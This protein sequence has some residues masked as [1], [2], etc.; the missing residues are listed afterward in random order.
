MTNRSSFSLL[1]PSTPPSLR[2]S[3]PQAK[4]KAS[5]LWLL[6]KA[7]NKSIPK[8]LRDPYYKNAQNEEFL[9]PQITQG[10]TNCEL[11]CMALSYIYEDLS[12]AD[13]DHIG[14]I[15]LLIKK[16]VQIVEPNDIDLTETALIQ[17][18]PIRMVSS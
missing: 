7:Y 2:N 18:A 16:G 6:S 13:L 11:Y 5:I 4:E 1:S 8:D 12:Y 10:L 15:H 9:K 3:H 17:N 14:V